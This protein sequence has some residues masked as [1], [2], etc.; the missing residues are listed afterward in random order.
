MDYFHLIVDRLGI[1]DFE[2]LAFLHKESA[3]KA[4]IVRNKQEI[5]DFTGFTE[6]IFRKII[7]RL[8]TLYLIESVGEGK[9]HAYYLTEYGIIAFNKMYDHIQ[10]AIQNKSNGDDEQ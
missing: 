1:Q 7:S 3:T 8:D 6:G 9:G 5:K 10:N 2:V 4:T